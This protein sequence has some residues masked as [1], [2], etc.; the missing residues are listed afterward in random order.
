MWRASTS[1]SMTSTARG[2]LEGCLENMG[3]GRPI[4]GA[5]RQT[6][7]TLLPADIPLGKL[8]GLQC[9]V[10]QVK[11]A[12]GGTGSM[13]HPVKM[14]YGVAF[15]LALTMASLAMPTSP[16]ASGRAAAPAAARAA[17]AAAATPAAPRR[18]RGAGRRPLRP[19]LRRRCSCRS[20]PTRVTANPDAFYGQAVTMTAS[21]EQVLSKTAFVGRSAP[22][23]QRRR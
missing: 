6:I 21:V 5:R 12:R 13:Y 22:G 14:R 15:A 16:A 23:R 19:R 9:T 1:S 8:S 4:R 20:R 17:R 11:D 3:S 2:S 10:W 7:A 18:T